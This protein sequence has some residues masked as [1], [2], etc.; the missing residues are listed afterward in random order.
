[1]IWK[2]MIINSK[3]FGQLFE[4]DIKVLIIDNYL[5]YYWLL[6]EIIQLSSSLLEYNLI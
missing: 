5:R 4:I 3:S 1:M 6:F 2:L